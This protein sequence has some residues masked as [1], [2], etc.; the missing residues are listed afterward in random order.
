MTDDEFSAEELERQRRRRLIDQA[1]D[2]VARLKNREKYREEVESLPPAEVARR[3]IPA[4]EDPVAKW[5]REM[6]AIAEAHAAEAAELSTRSGAGDLIYKTNENAAVG[7]TRADWS[8]WNAWADE[9]IQSALDRERAALVEGL[10]EG[11][12]QLLAD[13][14]E[15]NDGRR[16]RS[17]SRI[18]GRSHVAP[19]R[20]TRTP[21]ATRARARQGRRYAFAVAQSR[22]LIS[23]L[24]LSF[25]DAGTGLM[26]G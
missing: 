11:L 14:R 15:L 8:A 13:E 21:H 24:V 22:E 10:G 17:G 25:D 6:A 26:G 1:K 3:L 4:P 19:S 7:E 9:R 2:T 20:D 12:A 5:R 18:E 16:P 23:G